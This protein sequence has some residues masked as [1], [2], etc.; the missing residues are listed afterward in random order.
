MRRITF[1]SDS[2]LPSSSVTGTVGGC[3]PDSSFKTTCSRNSFVPVW[4]WYLLQDFYPSQKA[5]QN[6]LKKNFTSVFRCSSYGF[7]LTGTNKEGCWS[8]PPLSC[9]EN[10]MVSVSRLHKTGDTFVPVNM[11]IKLITPLSGSLSLRCSCTFT[12]KWE[13][14]T[15]HISGE[16]K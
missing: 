2:F 5:H 11:E 10:H 16:R 3:W 6:T 15:K 14:G 12:G 9:S 4:N 8:D 1:V 7:S 13:W